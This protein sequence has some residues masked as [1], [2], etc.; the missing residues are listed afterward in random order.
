M[1]KLKNVLLA[2]VA[3]SVFMV[4]PA[5]AQD[6][7]CKTGKVVGSYT[8]TQTLTD[9]WG[10]GTNVSHTVIFQLNLQSDGTALQNWT[11]FLDIPLSSGT[12]SPYIG[13]WKCRE[14]GKLV[15]TLIN[16]IYAPTRDALNDVL[17]PLLPFRPPVDLLLLF[18]QRVTYLLSVTDVNTLTRIQA[19]A[20]TYDV[21]QDPSD[22]DGGTLG[23]LDTSEFTYKRVVA[24]DADLLAP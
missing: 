17:H 1:L 6:K 23:A 8:R 20:R 12:A 16:A 10:D 15:V 3:L 2:L 9:L 18:H 7:G 11:G 24:S 4:I 22:P 19:R 21:T 13:S 14:D 5:F